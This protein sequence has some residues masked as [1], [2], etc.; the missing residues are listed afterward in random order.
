MRGIV[1]ARNPLTPTVKRDI[2]TVPPI[3]FILDFGDV[4][5]NLELEDTWTMLELKALHSETK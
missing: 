2:A 4:R 5:F 3:I 1:L